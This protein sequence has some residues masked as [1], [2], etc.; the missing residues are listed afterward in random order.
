MTALYMLDTNTVSQIVRGHSGAVGRMTALPLHQISISAITEG[1]LRFG[2]ERR[3]E[4]SRLHRI[5]QEFLKR[6]STKAWDGET[7]EIYGRLRAVLESAGRSLGSLD[8]LIAA[9]AI[10]TDCVLV[11]NDRAFAQVPD[12]RVEDWT[13]E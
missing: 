10:H 7:S 9:H 13:V 2:L 11:T 1:E 8:M 4:A 5:V 12:L 6:V 3:P